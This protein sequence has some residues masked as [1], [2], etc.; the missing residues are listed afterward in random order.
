MLVGKETTDSLRNFLQELLQKIEENSR[1]HLL[2]QEKPF[3]EFLLRQAHSYWSNIAK[4]ELLVLCMRRHGVEFQVETIS[5]K[6][7]EILKF[8]I[9]PYW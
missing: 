2:V 1:G 5:V 8:S 3:I 6:G 4:L 9:V 7:K